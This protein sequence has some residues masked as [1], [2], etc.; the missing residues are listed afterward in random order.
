MREAI[1]SVA[2]ACVS[3][4]YSESAE[5]LG[6]RVCTH[7]RAPSPWLSAT[8]RRITGSDRCRRAESPPWPRA[9]LCI[10]KIVQPALGLSALLPGPITQSGSASVRS[11]A[12]TRSD[13]PMTDFLLRLP[14]V[15]ARVG[16]SR[17]TIY[18]ATANGGFPRPLKLTA[19]TVAWRESEINAWIDSRPRAG[20]DAQGPDA[21]TR[22]T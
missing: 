3:C 8:C 22:G 14:D 4:V 5:P 6:L 18:R 7:A 1:A 10:I 9:H 21:S 19:Q 17:S 13:A 11:A 15:I 2:S 12:V 20:T 16:L